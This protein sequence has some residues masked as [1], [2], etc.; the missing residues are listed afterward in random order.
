MSSKKINIRVYYEDTDSGGIVYY[1]NY[2]KFTE[3]C[4]TELLRESGLSQTELLK[5]YDI[6]FIVHSV[7]MNYINPSYLDDNLTVE[8][9]IENFKKTSIVFDQK[10]YKVIKNNKNNKNNKIDII[11]SKCKIVCIDSN[12]KII[13][14]P[15]IISKKL[16]GEK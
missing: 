4:R 2:F 14:M 9:N 10:I 15:D 5:N 8:T 1:A 3:R 13:A 12:H 16:L 6:K 11:E 7:S